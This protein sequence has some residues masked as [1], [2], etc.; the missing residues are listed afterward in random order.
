MQ[1]RDGLLGPEERAVYR[2]RQLYAEHGY[3]RYRMNK[4]EHYDLYARNKDFLVSDSVLTFTDAGGRLLALR[5]DVTLSIVKAYRGTDVMRV[6]YNENVYRPDPG[7]GEYREIMQSG[8]ECLGPIGA[9]ESGEVLALAALSLQQLGGQGILTLSHQGFVQG[10]LN[11]ASQDA[12]IRRQLLA[13]IGQKNLG[14]LQALFGQLGIEGQ[15]ADQLALLITASGA[16]DVVLP[17]LEQA[18][19]N[20]PALEE[21]RALCQ[22]LQEQG[23]G[24]NLRIDFSIGGDATYYDGV[25][26]KGW[27]QGLPGIVLSG[28]RY[29]PLMRR[30]GKPQGAIGFAV[31]LDQLDRLQEEAQA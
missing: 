15:Q 13:L 25:V 16:P 31:Y 29:D 26:F 6:Q 28:G 14:G 18:G 5:P 21:L 27:L 2:L 12:D 11:A 23:Y 19:A 7:T 30:M 20:S 10:M 1:I 24:Q 3:S 8:V 22:G 4:F 17:A 9:R